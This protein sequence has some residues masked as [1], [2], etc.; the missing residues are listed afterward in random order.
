MRARL[1]PSLTHR[2]SFVWRMTRRGGRGGWSAGLARAVAPLLSPRSLRRRSAQPGLFVV[3]YTCARASFCGLAVCGI[4][5]LVAV[6]RNAAPRC[7]VC[8]GRALS[9]ARRELAAR[10]ALPSWVGCM[11]SVACVCVRSALAG[12][13]IFGGVDRAVPRA[14]APGGGGGGASR[15]H[16]RSSRA[17]FARWGVFLGVVGRGSLLVLCAHAHAH[18]P[19][20]LHVSGGAASVLSC[21][22]SRACLR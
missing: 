10:W 6:V 5:H 2:R 4:V 9:R 15:L 19:P 3:V 21:R 8:A 12:A 18:R 17:R 22:A 11:R 7:L 1:S 16:L 13:R 14:A 20:L